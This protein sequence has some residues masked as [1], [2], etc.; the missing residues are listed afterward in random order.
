MAWAVGLCYG[1]FR[2][3]SENEEG[4]A[5]AIITWYSI[6]PILP[7]VDTG[8][9]QSFLTIAMKLD[10]K[11]SMVVRFL[12]FSEEFRPSGHCNEQTAEDSSF[13]KTGK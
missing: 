9:G 7:P 4:C 3:G 6:R 12:E 10:D 11:N 1:D 5:G 13:C 2:F 8:N